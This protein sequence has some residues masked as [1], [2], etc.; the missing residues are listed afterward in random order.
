[1]R[2]AAD[3]LSKFPL[4]SHFSPDGLTIE[5]ECLFSDTRMTSEKLRL[6]S[7]PNGGEKNLFVVRNN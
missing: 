1:M 7:G 5:N 6:A 4:E 2:I 3:E